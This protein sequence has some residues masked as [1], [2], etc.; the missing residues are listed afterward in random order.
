MN[1][2]IEMPLRLDEKA[3]EG[4]GFGDLRSMFAKPAKNK[5][6]RR[7]ATGKKSKSGGNGGGSKPGPQFA[8]ASVR[9]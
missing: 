1:R 9:T 6:G 4:R 7:K 2:E 5:A 3:R 8:M